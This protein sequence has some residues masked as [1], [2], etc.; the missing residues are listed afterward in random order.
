[1]RTKVGDP[2]VH[3]KIALEGHRFS[4]KEALEYGLVD[5]VVSG[6]TEA[7]LEKAIQIAESKAPMAKTG[8]FGL[9]KVLL[10]NFVSSPDADMALSEGYLL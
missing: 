4:P 5:E 8:V 6:G 2:L 7:L 1:L 3:R 9:I 10:L